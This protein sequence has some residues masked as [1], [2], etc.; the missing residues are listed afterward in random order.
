MSWAKEIAW[1]TCHFVK[2]KRTLKDKVELTT[3]FKDPRR[4]KIKLIVVLLADQHYRND[5]VFN[6][7]QLSNPMK[8]IFMSSYYLHFWYDAITVMLHSWNR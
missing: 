3:L 5:K 6:D 8:I 2:H 1:P 4:S 7:K